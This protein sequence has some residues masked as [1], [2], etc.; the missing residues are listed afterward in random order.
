MM[1]KLNQGTL[2]AG[3]AVKQENYIWA[4]LRQRVSHGDCT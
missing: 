3:S 1:K 2:N 4:S